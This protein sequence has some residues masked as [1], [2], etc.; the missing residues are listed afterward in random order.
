MFDRSVEASLPAPDVRYVLDSSFQLGHIGGDTYFYLMEIAQDANEIVDNH[1][2][3]AANYDSH[4]QRLIHMGYYFEDHYVR[5]RATNSADAK[6]ASFQGLTNLPD[7]ILEVANSC[8]GK[9]IEDGHHSL[10]SKALDILN[11]TFEFEGTK[12]IMRRTLRRAQ[13]DFN[14]WTAKEI[15]DLRLVVDGRRAENRRAYDAAIAR[16]YE[17]MDAQINDTITAT[18]VSTLGASGSTNERSIKNT[19][20][21]LNERV[22]QQRR[23]IKRSVKFLT[24][25][26]GHDTTRMFI[27]GDRVRF[28]G[29]HAVYELQKVSNLSNPHG[30]YRALSVFDKEHPEL[31]LCNICIYTPDVPLLDHVASLVM[32]IRAGEEDEILKIGN[33]SNI[34]DKAYELPWLAPHLPVKDLELRQIS[35]NN[36]ISS[37][38]NMSPSQLEH[39][40]NKKA[41][42]ANIIKRNIYE[43]VLE[44]YADIF[45]AANSNRLSEIIWQ[46]TILA[47]TITASAISTN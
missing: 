5:W 12:Q 10:N 42:L 17:N 24:K 29:Q 3:Y 7:I 31:M 11:K 34:H 9:L 18:V 45:R 40:D 19:Q 21:L 28:E 2:E 16:M 1:Q 47:S 46:H 27:S 13:H 20:K 44:P 36:I 15:S 4:W 6:L 25:L 41:R 39:Y 32:H 14:G 35:L 23:A 22:K 37:F 8:A 38:T 43:E 30:G 33:A 26:V